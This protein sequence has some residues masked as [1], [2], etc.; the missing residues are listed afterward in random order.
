MRTE[1]HGDAPARHILTDLEY[2]SVPVEED[3]INRELHPEGMDRLARHDPETMAGR[4][5][6]MLQQPCPAFRAG[7]GNTHR[8]AEDNIFCEISYTHVRSL[9]RQNLEL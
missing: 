3:N 8:I 9:N 7:V 1:A 5:T 4:Q 6:F 2:F